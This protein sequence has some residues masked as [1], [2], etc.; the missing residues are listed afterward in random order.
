MSFLSKRSSIRISQ[1]SKKE[2]CKN[3][4][5]PQDY[6]ELVLKN[7]N[8]SLLSDLIDEWYKGGE[9]GSDNYMK[10]SK[11]RFLKTVNISD[12]YL[13][14][15]NS[16]EF[17]KPFI[18]K[19]P[20]NNDILIV[21]DGAGSGLGEV[22]LYKNISRNND[23]ISAGLIGVRIKD[24]K[25]YYALGFLKSQHF[26]DYINVNTAQGS[27]IRHS[28]L[29]ALNY[30]IPFPTKKNHLNP[31]LI[32]FYVSV[33]TQNII[34]K[35]EQI[36][37]KSK[38]I[39]ELFEKELKTNTNNIQV[40]KLPTISKLKLGNRLD[41]I[42]YSKRYYEY[43]NRIKSYI[44]GHYFLDEKD[45]APGKTPKDY[46]FSPT[47][48][49]NLF[50]QWI[51]PK[52]VY[53]R[54]LAY[55]T[56]IHTDSTSRISKNTIV[57]NGIRYVGNGI[58]IDNNEKIFA[59]QNTLIIKRFNNQLDQLFL[60][61]FLTSEIGKYMQMAQRNFGIVPILYKENLC[62][63]PIPE[64]D[65]AMKKKITSLYYNPI[66][67]PKIIEINSYLEN[68]KKRNSE[69]GIHQLSSEI[70]DLKDK[71]IN[72]IDK[73]INEVPIKLEL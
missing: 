60:Y 51:T 40:Y 5:C 22:A 8:T 52:N 39:D 34:D 23:Y 70:F 65:V 72:V 53:G 20:Q 66:E 9:I 14:N 63:I 1:L 32:E 42:I 21:K 58:Y 30:S 24:V 38:R 47:K 16:I 37:Y 31:S 44:N 19:K 57:L 11:Y 45:V 13:Y 15:E 68:E 35:E 10:K 62:K 29:V 27:T 54:R 26:K 28:K 36:A 41:T 50:Y 64:F 49:S 46:Y 7:G 2:F 56:Y 59:N 18:G 12:D 61:A 71:L 67:Q 48:K 33:L 17:C 3:S 55:K 69:L 4:L 43:E 6:K 25:K 73:I